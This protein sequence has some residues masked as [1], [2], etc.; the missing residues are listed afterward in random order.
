ML[1][2]NTLI[3]SKVTEFLMHARMSDVEKRLRVPALKL[4]M[5]SSKFYYG[6]LIV[7]H[8]RLAYQVFVID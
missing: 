4:L 6:F 5:V 3:L 8:D 1:K 2:E 7:Y